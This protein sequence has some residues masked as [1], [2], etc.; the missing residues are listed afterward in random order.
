MQHSKILTLLLMVAC[1]AGASAQDADKSAGNKRNSSS[2]YFNKGDQAI[3]LGIGFPNKVTFA[4]D[5]V[6]AVTGTDI[7]T[8]ASPQLTARYEYGLTDQIS[9]GL[10]TG[11]Y[12]GKTGEVNINLDE[13]SPDLGSVIGNIGNLLE[14]LLTPNSPNC[15]TTIDELTQ[16]ANYRISAYSLGGRVC[17]HRKNFMGIENIDIYGATT[18][19]YNFMTY[20]NTLNSKAKVKKVN[21]P[22]FSYAVVGG[23]RYFFSE[24]WGAYGEFGYSNITLFNLG[25]SYR[26]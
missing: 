1:L 23:A 15:Q 16:K 26:F 25:A 20:K 13:A 9:I 5:I 7:S 8:S 22:T 19:A 24:K 3:N 10:H 11:Y 12:T 18:F 4:L 2:Y 17:I 14:C 6:A 21:A